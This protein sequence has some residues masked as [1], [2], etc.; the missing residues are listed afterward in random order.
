MGLNVI[1]SSSLRV[2]YPAFNPRSPGQMALSWGVCFLS[3]GMLQSSWLLVYAHLGVRGSAWTAIRTN[4]GCRCFVWPPRKST[5]TRRDPPRCRTNGARETPF[6][7]RAPPDQI[8]VND[9]GAEP[10]ANGRAA[11]AGWF[12]FGKRA[13]KTG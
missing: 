1:S 13:T 5:A 2:Q 12:G 6:T 7:T 4:G 8:A 9:P 3:S 11:R 10:L